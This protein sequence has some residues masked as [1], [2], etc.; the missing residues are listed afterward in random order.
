MPD[1]GK[2]RLYRDVYA[3]SMGQRPPPPQKTKT[4]DES[5][6]TGFDCLKNPPSKKDTTLIIIYAV[7]LLRACVMT[8]RT[9]SLVEPRPGTL[10]GGLKSGTVTQHLLVRR[11][12]K[13]RSALS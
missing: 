1:K 8:V 4:R 2:E 11:N 5:P 7:K 9:L 6:K 3:T 10:V 13:T 12:T